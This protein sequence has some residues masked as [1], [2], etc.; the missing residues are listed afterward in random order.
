MSA[1]SAGERAEGERLDSTSI[2]LAILALLVDDREARAE[3]PGQRRIEIVLETAGLSASAIAL[4]LN[5][6][7]GTVQQTLYR[8]KRKS[9]P[10]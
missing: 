1:R 4:L 6:P 7:L 9:Q 8:A 10:D 3:R 5:K 2:L